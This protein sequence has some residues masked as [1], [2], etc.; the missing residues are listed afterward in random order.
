MRL[1]DENKLEITLNDRLREDIAENKIFGAA[2][3]VGQAGKTLYRNS[4][5]VAD[6]A[7]GAPVTEKTL[8]RIASMT[9]PITAVATLIL[10][11]RGKLSLDDPIE[12]YYP[13]F[14][15]MKIAEVGEGDALR[16]AGNA[17]TKITIRNILSH[18]SGIGSGRAGA[19]QI[20]AMTMEDLDTLGNTID[21]FSRQ[22]LS[23]EPGTKQEYSGF[24]AY[25]VLTGILEKTADED[26]GSFLY[27]EIFSRCNMED[28]TFVPTQLQWGRLAAMHDRISGKSCVSGV[29]PG[30]V[31]EKIPCTHVLGGAGLVSTLSDYSNFA[32]M[33]MNGGVYFGEHILSQA[34]V[35]ELATPQLPA[36]IQPG[37]QRWGLGVRVIVDGNYPGLPVGSF[38]W[39]GAYGPHFW[40]DPENQIAAVYMKNSRHDPGAGSVT[41]Y[42]FEADV[43]DS[44]K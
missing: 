36:S 23:F 15:N 40:I 39:S 24:P 11:E 5:G 2:V 21:F 26:Y 18:T 10:T 35:N 22:G 17:K 27:R 7:T 43:Y 29:Y 32:E 38:G 33:L 28:T 12:R 4:M 31:F 1:L 44:M 34:S 20:A 42:H 3:Y 19:L 13:Q 30:C 37:L 41:G 9:K 25:D 8:F 14:K 16:D 6:P